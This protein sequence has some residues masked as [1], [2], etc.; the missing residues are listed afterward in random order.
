MV[1]TVRVLTQWGG[2]GRVVGGISYTPYPLGGVNELRL[3][4]YRSRVVEQFLLQVQTFLL[5]AFCELVNEGERDTFE[6]IDC[7]QKNEFSFDSIFDHVEE[8]RHQ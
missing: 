8:F 6:G 4:E 5:K 7:D 1:D 2:V 3:Q